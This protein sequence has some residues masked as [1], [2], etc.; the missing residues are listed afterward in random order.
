MYTTELKAALA[1][2]SRALVSVVWC[3]VV[4]VVVVCDISSTLDEM[5][6][7]REGRNV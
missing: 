4:V 3:E 1:E 7:R 2:S 6:V 5:V